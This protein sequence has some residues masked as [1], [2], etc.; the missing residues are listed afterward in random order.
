MDDLRRPVGLTPARMDGP[1]RFPAFRVDHDPRSY[2]AIHLDDRRLR[3]RVAAL[4]RRYPSNRLVRQL[5]L[6]LRPVPG[7]CA[8]EISSWPAPRSRFH[9]PRV[10]RP[11]PGLP[12]PAEGVGLLRLPG[13]AGFRALRRGDSGGDPASRRW[14]GVAGGELRV[15][16]RRA[17]RCWRSATLARAIGMVRT[18]TDRNDQSKTNRLSPGAVR[19]LIAAWADSM[20]VNLNSPTGA[21]YSRYFNPA[22]Y[23]MRRRGVPWRSP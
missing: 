21:Y 11:V 2:P 16:A 13:A 4:A 5:A 19:E 9:H 18:K 3:R 23:S 12:F 14:R 1:P 17:S 6:C 8:R 7:A 15:G 10:Q 20:R 22:G